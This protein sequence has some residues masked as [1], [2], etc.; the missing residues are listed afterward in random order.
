MVLPLQEELGLVNLNDYAMDIQIP[1][2]KLDSEYLTGTRVHTEYGDGTIL[3]AAK[4]TIKVQLDSNITKT[5]ISKFSSF[6]ITKTPDKPIKT[7]LQDMI[8]ST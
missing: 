1:I 2:T 6:L 3:S 8:Y 4:T 5:G 7:L